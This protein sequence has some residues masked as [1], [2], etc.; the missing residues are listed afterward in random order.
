MLYLSW[1][2]NGFLCCMIHMYLFNKVLGDGKFK[3]SNK[4]I[5]SSII[6]SLIYVFLNN[7]KIAVLRPFLMHI[8]LFVMYSTMYRKS[9][10]KTFVGALYVMLLMLTSE[11]VCSIIFTNI[12]KITPVL[13][14][15]NYI[16]YLIMN[17]SIYIFALLFS[18]VK[19][20]SIIYYD[21]IKTDSG[22]SIKRAIIFSLEALTLA[23][24]ALY[25]N[26]TNRMPK[27][28]LFLINA[29]LV[30]GLIF[31]VSFFKERNYSNKIKDDYDNLMDYVKDYEKI[32]NEKSKNQ[33]EY[34]NQLVVI[35]NLISKNKNEALNYIEHLY[36]YEESTEEASEIQK[37]SYLPNGGIKGLIHYKIEQMHNKGINVFINISKDISSNKVTKIL[38]NNLY[39]ITHII[40]V[41]L[42][43]AIEASLEAKNHSIIIEAYVDKK[44]IVFSFSNTYLGTIN[45]NKVDKEGYTTKG[46]GHGYGLSVVRDLLNSNTILSQEKVLN[47]MYYVQKLII[48]KSK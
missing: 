22:K 4:E 24:F 35:K 16:H 8:M 43:N 39:D 44:E 48:K 34:K 13:V 10:I 9:I 45:L 31:I 21:F 41:Y 3:F 27:D 29:V 18:K 42:D 25:L 30:C 40:G 7:D 38:N 23:I 5:I 14:M 17:C 33:H 2:I 15:D 11:L 6:F 46:T 26:F 47:G 37:L 19:F 36:S 32:I 1:Y 12:L 20:I 28:L